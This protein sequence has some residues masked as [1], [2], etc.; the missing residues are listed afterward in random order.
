MF[1]LVYSFVM[2]RCSCAVCVSL[3]L[4]KFKG[5]TKLS[6]RVACKTAR[7]CNSVQARDDWGMTAK[8][9]ERNCSRVMGNG[10]TTVAFTW[11]DCQDIK[12]FR[13]RTEPS[14]SRMEAYT[15]LPSAGILFRLF[16][17]QTW[18]QSQYW[19]VD[20][21]TGRVGQPKVLGRTKIFYSPSLHIW[22]PLWSSGQ[23][24]WLQIRRP[25]FDSRH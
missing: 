3:W 4:K 6:N 15:A 24:S 2:D 14:T 22:P 23:S 18:S 25:G 12:V 16:S 19:S 21:A 17:E 10:C 8:D 1:T 11:K 5:L 20:A 7:Q 13:T 9:F